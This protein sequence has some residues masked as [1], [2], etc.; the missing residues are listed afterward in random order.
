MVCLPDVSSH[1]VKGTFRGNVFDVIPELGALPRIIQI[2]WRPVI[3]SRYFTVGT[4]EGGVLL[5]PLDDPYELRY[6]Q[7]LPILIIPDS[8]SDQLFFIRSEIASRPEI[9]GIVHGMVHAC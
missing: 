7:L 2:L 9:W 1:S 4:V 8:S 3:L 5:T 6:L